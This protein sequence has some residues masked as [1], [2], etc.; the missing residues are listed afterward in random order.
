MGGRNIHSVLAATAL[1][2]GLLLS[3]CVVQGS[4]AGSTQGAPR[5]ES[6]VS[7]TQIEPEDSSAKSSGSGTTSTAQSG[8]KATVSTGQKVEAYKKETSHDTLSSCLGT[9][10]KKAADD[11]GNPLVEKDTVRD[12]FKLTIEGEEYE[13]PCPVSKFIDK[14]WRFKLG[15][16]FADNKYDP[17]FSFD[18]DLW[19][20]DDENYNIS[21]KLKNTSDEIVTGNDLMVVGITIEPMNSFVSFESAAGVDRD[22]DLDTLLAVLGCNDESALQ[23]NKVIVQYHVSL[24]EKPFYDMNST[25]YGNIS[26]DWNKTGRAMTAL[27]FELL[28]PWDEDLRLTDEELEKK[29]EDAKEDEEYDER[30]GVGRTIEG[31]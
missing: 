31:I 10:A 4:D 9:I 15:Y 26:Y 7:V 14:D 28:D 24:Y 17:D 16:S 1:A 3:G 20:K 8:D 5:Q 19:Y 27:S 22:S 21:V 25:L 30:A 6:V 13:L 23:D 11:H 2:S 12:I 18:M 29:R